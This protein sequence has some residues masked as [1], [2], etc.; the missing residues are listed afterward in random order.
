MIRALLF[1]ACVLLPRQTPD[2]APKPGPRME[3]LA[4]KLNLTED[5]R[6]RIQAIRQRQ[7]AQM[8]T[9][10]PDMKARRLALRDALKDPKTSEAELRRRFDAVND[11][12]FQMLLA[13][14]QT[15][16]EIRSVLTPE[17]QAQADAL[18]EQ[19]RA[20]VRAR[21]RERLSIDP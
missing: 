4:R 10:Q 21:M 13:G 14:R 6:T 19:F 12:R 3:R 16:Q 7:R 5:Q 2:P 11:L 20:R 18:R 8:Q 9:R 15:R 1:S 17:Q